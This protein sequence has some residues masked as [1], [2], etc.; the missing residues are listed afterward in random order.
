MLALNK[1]IIKQV[2]SSLS[3]FTQLADRLLV[4]QNENGFMKL[5]NRLVVKTTCK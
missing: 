1:V 3:L 5:V 4:S 2:A